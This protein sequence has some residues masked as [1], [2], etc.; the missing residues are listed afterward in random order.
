ML[1]HAAY[2]KFCRFTVIIY[3]LLCSAPLATLAVQ[4]PPIDT[5]LAAATASQESAPVEALA[6]SQPAFLV[7]D[8]TSDWLTTDKPIYDKLLISERL[9]AG[10]ATT[11]PA[12][13]QYYGNKVVYLTFDDGPDPTN[14][15]IVLALLKEYHI[16]A[17]F[18]LIGKQAE[19]YPELVK[20]I[21]AEGHAIG[22]HSFNHTYKELY[23]SPQAYLAQLHHTD[24]IIKQAIGLRP[25][26]SRAPG[27]SAGNFSKAYWHS[28]EQ[29]G[30]VDV[31]WNISSGDAS[32]GKAAELVE[33]IAEQ[34][35]NKSLWSHATVLMHDGTGHGETMKALRQ[36]IELFHSQ[37]FEFRV[38]NLSTPPAW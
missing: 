3:I 7:I 9:R 21:F 17:T 1:H 31:G 37:G 26:I 11:L 6:A 25:R 27:G 29:E 20:R 5:D 15:P 34:L 24:E 4:P 2:K 8:N 28:L 13:P 16:H 35:Q 30:Y 36:I 38:V 12:L 32:Q 22:N 19:Q 23:R 14:T 18:F 33:N 10:L